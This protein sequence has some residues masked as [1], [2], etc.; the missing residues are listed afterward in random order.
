MWV[1]GG[2]QDPF[3]HATAIVPERID[4][5]VDYS[6]SGP[7]DALG[8]GIVTYAQAEG[9]GWGPYSCSGGHGERWCIG[10]PT[11]PIRAASCT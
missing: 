3:A 11:A 7:I 9:A 2:Y 4:M 1:A 10:S 8:D 6:A 5:G